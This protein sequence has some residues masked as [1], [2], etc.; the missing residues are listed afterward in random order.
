MSMRALGFAGIGPP[1]S[2]C[3]AHVLVHGLLD[4]VREEA[5]RHVHN[6]GG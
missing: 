6:G 3:G 4:F 2:A 5:E 1:V